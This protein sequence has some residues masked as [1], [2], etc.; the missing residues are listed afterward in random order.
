M[1]SSGA[2][3]F[4][5]GVDTAFLFILGISVFFLVAITITM[6]W[7]VIRYRRSKNPVSA[8]IPGNN[9]LELVWTLIPVVLVLGMFWF[10]LKGYL[11]M[12][13]I[14]EKGLKVR[15]VAR[16]WSWSFEYENG[17]KGS[18]LI[19]PVNKPVVLDLVSE[20][21]IHS[22][23]IPAFRVKED[24]VPGRTNRMW[25]IPEL[26]GEYDIYCAEYCGL[27]HAYM[28]TTI[29]VLPQEKFDEWFAAG[30]DTTQVDMVSAGFEVLKVYGCGACHSTDGTRIVGTSFKD[31]YGSSVEVLEGSASKTIVV[32]EEYIRKSVNDPNAQV[33]KGFTPGLMPG[34]KDKISEQ[35]MVN[36]ISYL[37][38]VSKNSGGQ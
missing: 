37:K 15:A 31:L 5:Q 22:L 18:K 12:R 24:V 27:R 34:F 14:P 26:E 36:L 20:D 38:S 25:F 19:V 17:K 11:P 33:V 16:M 7:F 10:G 29:Q 1:F 30:K 4:T 13:N 2:S 9:L 28:L 3:N 8:D 32:D 23:Y 35:E 21:V 6:V